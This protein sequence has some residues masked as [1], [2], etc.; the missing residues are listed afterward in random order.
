MAD[1]KLDLHGKTWRESQDEFIT[2]YNAALD[3][4]N[5]TGVTLTVVQSYGSTIEGGVLR[6]R[7]RAYLDRLDDFLEYT[8]GEDMDGNMG[9]TY[10]AQ[11]EPIPTLEDALAADILKFCDRGQTRG[12]ITGKIRRHG[13][14]KVI[15]A[16]RSLK[17]QGR[18]VKR[19]NRL[20]LVVY[21]TS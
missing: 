16:I 20:G 5:G 13:Q 9:C 1:T 7:L 10:I 18:M 2:F 3:N 14:P 6:Q 11:I 17:R 21:G 19:I 15:I 4:C 12:K 8:P